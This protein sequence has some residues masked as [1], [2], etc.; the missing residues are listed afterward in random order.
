MFT[1][2]RNICGQGRVAAKVV[3]DAGDDRMYGEDMVAAGN[4]NLQDDFS[5]RA[6]C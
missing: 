4:A 1:A 6:G 2:R 5:C 3:D